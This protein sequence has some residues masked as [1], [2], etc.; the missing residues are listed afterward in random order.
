MNIIKHCNCRNEDDCPSPGNNYECCSQKVPD[1]SP[2]TFGMWIE[3]DNCDSEKGLPKNAHKHNENIP[4]SEGYVYGTREGYDDSNY[5]KC[6]CNQYEDEED[7]CIEW[8]R[9]F[10]LLLIIMI[11]GGIAS[12]AIHLKSRC[13][14]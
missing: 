11:L 5:R 1:G 10:N 14:R 9:A 13:V 7:S 8:S 12:V 2:P 4:V 3:K 6:N